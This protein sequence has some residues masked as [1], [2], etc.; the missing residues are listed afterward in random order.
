MAEELEALHQNKT[1]ILT[2]KRPG[3]NV[4]GCKWIFRTKENAD[5]SLNRY[6]AR[7]VA[8]GFHQREGQD[9]DLTYSPVIK[10]A[11]VRTVLSI[12]VAQ[13]WKL[14]HLDV[15]NAFLNGKLIEDVYMEQPPG[16]RNSIFPDHVC[17]LR[18][19]LYGLKQ[20]PRAWYDQLRKFLELCGFKNAAADTS[21]FVL[22]QGSTI[23][24]VLIYVD[25]FIITGNND[26][27]LRH[28]IG[29][30]CNRFKCR[31]LGQLSYFLGLEMNVAAGKTTVTQRKYSVDLLTKFG[32]Q[33]CK[34]ACTP[35]AP[36]QQLSI[37]KGTVLKDPTPY[38]SLVGALQYL[39]IT[40]PDIA[41]AVNQ[42][43]KF[44]HAPTDTHLTA[45][46]R[47]LRYVKRTITSG[48]TFHRSTSTKL[49]I[50]VDSDWAGDQDDRRSTTGSCIFLGP[51]LISWLSKKQPTVSRSSAEAEY[52]AIAGVT[53]ELRWLCCLLRDLGIRLP[54]PPVIHTDSKSAIFMA[55]NPVVRLN[56]RHIEV[57]YHFVRELIVRKAIHITY[58]PSERQ[59]ADI[60]T[61]ALPTELFMRHRRCLNL[62]G[63]EGG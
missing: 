37:K 40:R 29:Q 51:N 56:S 62:A 49:N 36:G 30:V 23:I 59:T 45:A 54:H 5:G 24:Y 27:R 21:L 32:L 7:L 52:R 43:C 39:I 3:M 1:W 46:K 48:L 26:N 9:Y 6:K 28:F 16:H 35:V 2:P 12:A 20:A 14:H 42:V 44:M 58:I 13:D 38:R 15:C 19:A 33:D 63:V 50:M 4:V 22:M 10:A 60:F 61:K 17:K 8:K 55:T 53:A 34:P 11:T 57:D 25:D 47:I 31:D 41:F 18:R